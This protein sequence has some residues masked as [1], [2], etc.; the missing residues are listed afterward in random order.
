M[1]EV[2]KPEEMVTDKALLLVL[3]DLVGSENEEA[4]VGDRLKCMKLPFFA[5][6]Q[7]FEQKAKGF[8][9]TF[10]RYE[11]GPI[12]KEVYNAWNH[13]ILLGLLIE[14]R[15]GFRV[16]PEGNRLAQ[17]IFGDMLTTQANKFF[18]E[19]IEDVAVR[20]GRLS[21]PRIRQIVYD[22]EVSLPRSGSRMKVKDIELG[23]D[24]I[25][26]LDEDEA[27]LTL[28][29]DPAWMETLAIELNP[30][31]KEGLLKAFDDYR[32]GRILSHEEVW[33]NVNVSS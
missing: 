13:L 2:R 1:R 4:F 16:T 24:I 11:H 9:L 30:K 27:K 20:Y 3:M 33:Q 31:N 7:M 6:N 28:K 15:H 25:L 5:A 14:D 19:T 18:R 21:T 17:A 23:E 32:E 10:F 12:S 8:N 22:I 29:L 26:I